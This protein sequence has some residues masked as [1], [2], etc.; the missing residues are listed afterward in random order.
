MAPTYKLDLLRLL[1][2]V[3]EPLRYYLF[4][5]CYEKYVIIWATKDQ[6]R[7][8]KP[9]A[10]SYPAMAALDYQS[11]KQSQDQHGLLVPLHFV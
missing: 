11:A 9:F 4:R 6:I 1:L 3:I 5:T 10:R 7:C 2:Q 8:H